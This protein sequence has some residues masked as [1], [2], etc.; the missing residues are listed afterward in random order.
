MYEISR[1]ERM[2]EENKNKERTKNNK[3]KKSS[4]VRMLKL[5]LLIQQN[6]CSII[7]VEHDAWFQLKG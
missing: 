2:R 4:G 5:N 6:I 7:Y 3:R 1:T